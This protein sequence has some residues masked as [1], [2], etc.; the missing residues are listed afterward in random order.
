MTKA[1]IR[2]LI[3][4]CASVLLTTLGEAVSVTGAPE[5]A[6][7]DQLQ[8]RSDELSRQLQKVHE[9]LFKLQQ[10]KAERDEQATM[11]SAKVKQ[12]EFEKAYEATTDQ[13]RRA[14]EHLDME[15]AI[16][17]HRTEQDVRM[18]KILS[19][20]ESQQKQYQEYLDSLTKK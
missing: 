6:D 20:W 10:A 5:D 9:Q 7:I 17:K 19:T 13:L 1:R 4:V 11:E 2:I 16:L 15:E 8:K 14:T 3:V 12:A 18:D